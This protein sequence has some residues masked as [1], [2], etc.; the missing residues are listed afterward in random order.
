MGLTQIHKDL[1]TG[2]S[3]YNKLQGKATGVAIL[4][5]LADYTHDNLERVRVYED[6]F[7]EIQLDWSSRAISSV[8]LINDVRG[9]GTIESY[10]EID[11][12]SISNPYVDSTKYFDSEFT[13]YDYFHAGETAEEYSHGTRVAGIINQIAPGAKI[14]S[15]ALPPLEINEDTL[16]NAVMNFLDFLDEKA[17]VYNIRVVNINMGWQ[18]PG[19]QMSQGQKDNIEN[20][21]FQLVKPESPPD[22]GIVFVSAAGNAIIS[23]GQTNIVYPSHLANNWED[24]FS[25]QYD[26][27][28][29]DKYDYQNNPA[30]ATGFISVSSI[31][32]FD[33]QIGLRKDDYV[34]DEDYDTKQQ[35]NGDL[36]LMGSGVNI[37]TTSNTRDLDNILVEIP[38][39]YF[40]GTSAAAP[41]VTGLVALLLGEDSSIKAFEIEKKLTE[42]A[43]FDSNVDLVKPELLQKY[44]HGMINPIRTLAE[45]DPLLVNLDSDLDG[46]LDYE[47]LYLSHTYINDID[48]DDDDLSDKW[49]FDYGTNP[50]V[51]DRDDDPDFDGL[52]NYNEK[53]EGTDPLDDD[54]DDDWLLDGEEVNTYG[55]NPLDGDSDDDWLP[56]GWEVEQGV[57]S[58]ILADTDGNSTLDRDEDYD[59]DGLTAFEELTHGTSDT[60]ADTD[61]DLISDYDEIHF[62]MTDPLDED[63]DHNGVND[64]EED[65]DNDGLTNLLECQAN[66]NPYLQ[67]TDGDGLSDGWEIDNNLDPLVNDS[68]ND[69]DNDGSTNLEECSHGTDPHDSDTDND[70][71]P[72]GWE[73]TYSLNPLSDDSMS[74]A[75][76]DNLNNIDEFTSG[77][78]P[79]DTDTDND[80]LNDKQEFLNGCDPTDSDTDNDGWSDY[81]EVYTSGTEPD[82]ADTDN[83]GIADK[84]EYNW[85]RN[86]YGQSSSSAYSKIKDYDTDNDGL[87]DGWEKNHGVNPLDNDCD[88]DG[89][90]D[91]LEV[92]SYQTDPEDSDS[93]NDGYDDLYEII[94]GTDP[95]DPTDYPG[96]GWGW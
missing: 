74:D 56:D 6:E 40:T 76:G 21:I 37:R 25:S 11:I 34:Y 8:V 96:G 94:N 61:G 33:S 16:Y 92:N 69:P 20:R 26:A 89:L 73:I 72:D 78:D 7:G 14:I 82:D 28:I 86:T 83:D 54:T 91:G 77:A 95:N 18:W 30:I 53:V 50:L 17:D 31:H 80:G 2:I 66:T 32:D 51:Y 70:G 90:L 23:E 75:D 48:Y 10:K 85:W 36:K 49:E 4:D 93:D 59:K 58:P 45:Y 67:D 88:N 27:V 24:Y 43:I 84:T 79:T 22:N 57:Y 19:I 68:A 35:Y 62:T 55:T 29:N 47:E 9:G 13:L 5:L 44:G 63:T 1:K 38:Q 3:G 12:N 81:F 87:S 52:T 46:L 60:N 15:V 39:V 65:P 71:M 64:S 41:V 42:N